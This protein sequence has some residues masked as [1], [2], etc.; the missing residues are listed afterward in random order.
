[1][2]YGSHPLE[3]WDNLLLTALAYRKGDGRALP[4]LIFLSPIFLAVTLGM[5]RKKSYVSKWCP[6]FLPNTEIEKERTQSMSKSLL[7][8]H[9]VLIIFSSGMLEKTIR[10]NLLH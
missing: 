3:E 8:N 5:Q 2:L 7:S 6:S 4:D 1:M 9:I 10:G